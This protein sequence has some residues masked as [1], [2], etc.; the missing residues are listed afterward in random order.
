MG[1]EPCHLCIFQRIAVMAVGAVFL[2]AAVHGPGATGAR[3]YGV[4]TA[5][6]ALGGLAVAGRHTWIQL[7]PPGSVPACGAPLDVLF[8]L[9]P[10]QEVVLKVFRGGGE[11]QKVD[12]AFL[13]LTMPMW[14]LAV[15]AALGAFALW[16]NFRSDAR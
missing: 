12:W 15:F 6:A 1:L 10:L 8:D 16:A 4:L 14:L 7:Q 11:C 2:V 5:L 3:V 9:L 13:G